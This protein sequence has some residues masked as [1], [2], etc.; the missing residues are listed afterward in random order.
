[1]DRLGHAA[2]NVTLTTAS[3]LVLALLKFLSRRIFVVFLG[4]EYLG[5]SGLFTDILS[6]L[7]LAELGFG[8]SVTYSLYGPA[9]RG[10]TET[11][12]SLMALY[13]RVYRLVGLTVLAVG[14]AL[15]PFL[16]FFV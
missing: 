11:V 16:D 4:K 10:D 7:S 9:A 12:K 2:K 14:L 5:I 1:M 15:T 3:E 13:R 6:L 8:V